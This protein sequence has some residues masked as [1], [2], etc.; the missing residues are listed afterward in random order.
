M[1]LLIDT[2][3]R[4]SL[5]RESVLKRMRVKDSEK[6]RPVLQPYHICAVEGMFCLAVVWENR[7]L[8]MDVTY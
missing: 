5:I 7:P 8:T 4:V 6:A 1:D 2:A 3:S